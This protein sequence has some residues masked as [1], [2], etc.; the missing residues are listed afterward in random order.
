[1]HVSIHLTLGFILFSHNWFIKNLNN[2][3][4][5]I[6]MIINFLERLFCLINYTFAINLSMILFFIF[7]VLIDCLNVF[8]LCFY[9]YMFIIRKCN[10]IYKFFRFLVVL[11]LMFELISLN[12]S[13]KGII[14]NII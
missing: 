12:F 10:I 2:F 14:C 9:F 3:N 4:L 11:A 8:M 13:F 6:C 1:L 5:F 7:V